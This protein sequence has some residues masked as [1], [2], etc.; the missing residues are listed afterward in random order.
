MQMRCKDLLKALSEYVDG[1]IDPAICDEFERHLRGCNPCQIVIDNVR[2]T[3]TLYRAGQPHKLPVEFRKKL[4]K[5]LRD[6]WKQTRT[7]GGNHG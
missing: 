4:H 1:T 7:P 6:R 5:T 3:I 2:K